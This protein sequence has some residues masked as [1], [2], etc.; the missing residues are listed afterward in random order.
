MQYQLKMRSQKHTKD[1]KMIKNLIFIFFLSLLLGGCKLKHII[2]DQPYRQVT[3]HYP[4]GDTIRYE[5]VS[6]KEMKELDDY[7]KKMMVDRN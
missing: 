7:Y 4:H 3:N 1:G 5:K 2:R 6:T